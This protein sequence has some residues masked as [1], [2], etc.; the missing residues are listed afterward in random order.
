MENLV[1][2]TPRAALRGIVEMKTREEV[3]QD[4][5]MLL[6]KVSEDWEYGGDYARDAIFRGHGLASLDVVML[7]TAIQEHYGRVFPFMKFFAEMASGKYP[8]S[9]W[10]CGST[11]FTPSWTGGPRVGEPSGNSSGVS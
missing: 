9:P 2:A 6:R 10:V 3:L 11:S 8:T 1:S 4:V 7:G 5:V